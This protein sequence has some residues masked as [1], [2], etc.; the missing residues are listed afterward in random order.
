MLENR[1][2]VA[3]PA[4]KCPPG[5]PEGPLPFRLLVTEPA[6]HRVVSLP[7]PSPFLSVQ[8][9]GTGLKLGLVGGSSTEGVLRFARSWYHPE[10]RWGHRAYLRNVWLS[11]PVPA[12]A[13]DSFSFFPLSFQIRF[14]VGTFENDCAVVTRF[15]NLFFW[16]MFLLWQERQ[17]LTVFHFCKPSYVFQKRVLNSSLTDHHKR[18]PGDHSIN[19][20]QWK[21]KMQSWM[22]RITKRLKGKTTKHYRYLFGEIRTLMIFFL[23]FSWILTFLL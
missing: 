13:G 12:W 6:L 21:N 8:L 11:T 15:K 10:S 9:R 3:T 1:L 14:S 2:S 23:L 5:S 4:G 19:W 18:H 22:S 7:Q 20:T 17:Y 16:T